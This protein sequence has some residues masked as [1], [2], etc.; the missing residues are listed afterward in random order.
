MN[1]TLCVKPSVPTPARIL[2]LL[3]LLSPPSCR[4]KTIPQ[5]PQDPTPPTV[6]MTAFVEGANNNNSK[7][8]VDPGKGAMANPMLGKLDLLASGSDDESGVTRVVIEGEI[9]KNCV[10]P[11]GT[12]GQIENQTI[13]INSP[14]PDAQNPSPFGQA[15]RVRVATGAFSVA[16]FRRC[17]GGNVFQGASGFFQATAH[18]GKNQISTTRW[19]E[20]V[21]P[22]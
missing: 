11:N 22:R 16:D 7:Y 15:L 3:L 20:F 10:D 13:R 9:K 18:N 19:F 6:G 4:V 12:I 5:P 21:V 8:E 2:L 1:G 14:Q 17:R